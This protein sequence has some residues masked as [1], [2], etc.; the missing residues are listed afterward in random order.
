MGD[1]LEIRRSYRTG[2]DKEGMFFEHSLR[3]GDSVNNIIKIHYDK[4]ETLFL[5]NMPTQ[6]LKQLLITL[7]GELRRREGNE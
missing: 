6:T 4:V 5:L 3:V 7:Q 2:Y 1:K